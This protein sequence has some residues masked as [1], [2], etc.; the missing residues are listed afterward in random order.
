MVSW[1]F[2]DT[3]SRAAVV[4]DPARMSARSAVTG[5]SALVDLLDA[6][7]IRRAYG[8]TGGPIAP[9]CDAG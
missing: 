6:L 4:H 7:G 1:G 8:I 2:S 3:N 9:L 5:A